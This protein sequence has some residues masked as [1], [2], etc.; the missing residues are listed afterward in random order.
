[1][2]TLGGILSM[3]L[4]L[5]LI[6]GKL[7]SVLLHQYSSVQI[8]NMIHE[9]LYI[10]GHYSVLWLLVSIVLIVMV[11]SAYTITATGKILTEYILYSLPVFG[12]WNRKIMLH[13]ITHTL[14]ILL[15][16]GLSYQDALRTMETMGGDKHW[17]SKMLNNPA[18][19]TLTEKFRAVHF[20]PEALLQLIFVGENSNSIASVLQKISD[21]YAEEIGAMLEALAFVVVPVMILVAGLSLGVMLYSFR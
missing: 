1:M 17:V 18:Q 20:F 7:I 15:A 6:A 2:C 19:T 14:S 4:V 8:T 3:I 11:Y 12:E 10:L 13:R 16:G 5:F 9:S 21:Y